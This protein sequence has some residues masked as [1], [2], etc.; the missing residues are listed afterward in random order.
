MGPV[1]ASDELISKF[2]F[3]YARYCVRWIV[4]LGLP[5][6]L[7]MLWSPSVQQSPFP[8]LTMFLYF[9]L[10]IGTGVA[11]VASLGF[12]MGGLWSRLGESSTRNARTLERIRFTA[13]AALILPACVLCIYLSISGVLNLEVQAFSRNTRHVISWAAQPGWFIFNV[14]LWG[15][16]GAAMLVH[17]MRK[18]RAVYAA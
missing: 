16:A 7:L 14:V 2:R 3:R 18:L 11:V 6:L 17:V 13:L 5:L 1:R 8:F 10:P 15:G 9:G 4:G 12:L